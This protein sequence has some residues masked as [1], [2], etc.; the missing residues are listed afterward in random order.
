MKVVLA[1]TVIVR[2]LILLCRYIW[3]RDFPIQ[4]H[5]SYNLFYPVAD[6]H[7]SE[8]SEGEERS[9]RRNLMPT[10]E[11]ETGAPTLKKAKV[12][13]DGEGNGYSVPPPRFPPYP[14]SGTLQFVFG[15]LSQ[16]LPFFGSC[17]KILQFIV[18]IRFCTTLTS[19]LWWRW[20]DLTGWA[21]M[22]H[23][24]WSIS[25]RQKPGTYLSQWMNKSLE[26]DLW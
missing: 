16:K 19:L 15:K 8:K 10:E 9:R 5:V 7:G 14:T 23:T 24:Y 25:G 6:G 13:D 11:I 17:F 21:H 3:A 18:G 22:V 4:T 26:N 2:I 12:G 20:R 1:S